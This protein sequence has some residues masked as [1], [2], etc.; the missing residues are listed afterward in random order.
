MYTGVVQL[1]SGNATVNIDNCAGMTEGTFVALNRCVRAFTTNETNWDLVKGS[2]AGNILTVESCVADSTAQVSWM[3][4]GERQDV[5]MTNPN[6]P[7]TDSG[8]H[9]IVEPIKPAL[10]GEE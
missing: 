1:T 3:V 5:A 7:M 10:S 2:V 9:I 8:G 6:N 4:L